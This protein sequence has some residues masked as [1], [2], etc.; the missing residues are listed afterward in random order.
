MFVGPGG[1]YGLALSAAGT[2]Y[3]A[4]NIIHRRPYYSEAASLLGHAM[5]YNIAYIFA[6][7]LRCHEYQRSSITRFI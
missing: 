5:I 2:D 7:T 3:T 6:L 1:N 4:G